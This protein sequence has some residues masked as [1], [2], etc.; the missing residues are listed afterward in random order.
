MIPIEGIQEAKKVA[1][2]GGVDNL[3]I[4]WEREQI[5]GASLVEA[6]EV[7]AKAPTAICFRHDH[8]IGYPGGV[9]DL[10]YQLGLLQLLNFLDDEVLF[11]GCLSSCILLHWM[12]LSAHD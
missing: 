6:G 2:G 11:L 4:P 9:G 12:R 5:L 7:H 10:V 8:K 1:A 3:I